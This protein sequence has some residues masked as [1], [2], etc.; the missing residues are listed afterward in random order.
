M[1][2]IAILVDGGCLLKRLPTVFPGADPKTPESVAR[3][4]RRL[5]ASHLDKQNKIARAVDAR[6]LLYRVF[7]YDAK[8]Y[9]KKDHRPIS[10]ESIDYARTD[11]AKFRLGLFDCLQTHAEHRRPLG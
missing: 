6:S 4:I 11:E 7:Y 1:T 2:R 8:P 10:G 9:L 3:A 5:V